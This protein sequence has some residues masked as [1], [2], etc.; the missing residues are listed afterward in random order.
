MEIRCIRG[1][2]EETWKNFK[3]LAEKN[4]LKMSLLL[5][6]MIKEME[7][8]SKNFWGRILNDEKNL[9]ESEAEDLLKDVEKSRKERGF[10]E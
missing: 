6:M 9:S 10:R 4:N 5:K 1:V 2:D 7:N 8:K 3:A